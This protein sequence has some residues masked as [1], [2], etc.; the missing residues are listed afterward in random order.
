M[1]GVK[2]ESQFVKITKKRKAFRWKVKLSREGRQ[3]ILAFTKGSAHIGRL[4]NGIWKLATK[5]ELRA[6]EDRMLK[7]NKPIPPQLREVL[8]CLQSE[9]SDFQSNISYKDWASNF[10][11]NP[12]SI[13]G[14]KIFR[15]CRRHARKMEHL[16]G[17]EWQNFLQYRFDED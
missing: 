1:F 15:C 2:L 14:K 6:D 5:Q 10:G 3:F 9:C 8:E 17:V 4:V 12:D 13:K 7:R 16:L 11:Y